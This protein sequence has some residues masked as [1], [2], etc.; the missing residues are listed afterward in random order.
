MT[1]FLIRY[2]ADNE[3]ATFEATGYEDAADQFVRSEI[4]SP[5]EQTSRDAINDICLLMPMTAP[6]NA[7]LTQTDG[8]PDIEWKSR[9]QDNLWIGVK[10]VSIKIKHDDEGIAVD[11]YEQE[12]GGDLGEATGSTYAFFPAGS[13][14]D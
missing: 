13:D 12:E 10:G 11:L 5:D 1:E 9:P 2:G 6:D 8:T 7:V 3:M 4:V 14:E